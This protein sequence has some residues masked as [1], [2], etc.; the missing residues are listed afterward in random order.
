[1]T[2]KK[3]TSLLVNLVLVALLLVGTSQA[4]TI[5]IVNGDGPNE[6]FNDTTPFTPVGGNNAT[7]LG[8]AR[9]NAVQYAA[10]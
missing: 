4:A 1:M 5:V 2:M 7:T 6:G 8:Q 9:L 3:H 10:D